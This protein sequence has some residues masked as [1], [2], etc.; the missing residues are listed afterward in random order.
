MTHEEFQQATGADPSSLNESLR[1]HMTQCVACAEYH[2]ELLRV[3]ARLRS[4]LMIWVPPATVP[5][6]PPRR[7]IWR[8]SLAAAIALVTVVS[9]ILFVG[10]PRQ[11][12]AHAVVLHVDGEP[13][14]FTQTTPVDPEELA[15][16]MKASQLEFLRGGPTVTY[17]HHCVL[18]GHAVPHLAVLTAHGPVIVM[19]LTEEHVLTR[20]H[21]AE[22]GY[23][24]V[25][26]PAPRGSLAIVSAH[27]EDLD[28]IA[29]AVRSRIRYLD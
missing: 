16:V 13:T 10:L 22:H 11:A 7:A 29:S 28:A 2:L 9:M 12:L 19:V 14:A 25:L 24:G 5:A 17:A 27:A 18:R 15:G 6:A 3:E 1:E 8:Y 20:Q 23:E 26:V 21:F 4:A